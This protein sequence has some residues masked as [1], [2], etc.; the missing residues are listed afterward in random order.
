MRW[1]SPHLS[2]T[3]VALVFLLCWLPFSQAV[4]QQQPSTPRLSPAPAPNASPSPSAETEK[5]AEPE[6]FVL[7]DPSHGGEDRGAV[8]APKFNEK[9]VTLSL[10]RVLRKELEERG[11]A[12]RL[13]RDSDISVGLNHRAELCNQQ[14]PGIYI[15][16]HAGT[17][18]Q[19][20]RVYTPLLPSK[21]PPVGTFLPWDDAQAG[22]LERSSAIAKAVTRELAKRDLKATDFQAFLR[23]LNN[24]IGPAIAVELA[25]DRANVRSLED[26]K[27]QTS[28]ASAIASGIAQTRIRAG[29]HK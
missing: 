14:R 10:A 11:I 1:S 17:P 20:V 18:G 16:L 26:P 5:P 21:Q 7:I 23:P 4:A 9:D 22:S 19:G 27:M 15:A 3:G 24:I 12:A 29:G 25:V 6:F 13:L 8:L 28:V 2:M